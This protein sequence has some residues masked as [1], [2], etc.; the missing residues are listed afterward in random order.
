M[1]LVLVIIGLVLLILG[2]FTLGLVLVVVGIILL[3]VPGPFYGV[4]YWSGRRRGPP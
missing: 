1:G 4:S 3:F 2:Y